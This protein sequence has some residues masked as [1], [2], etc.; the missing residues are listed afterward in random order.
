MAINYSD[1]WYDEESG[2]LFRSETSKHRNAGKSA[3]NTINGN[4]YRHTRVGNSMVPSHRIIWEMF[5][6]VLPKGLVIDH[7]NRNKLDN[8]LC[9][10]RAVTQAEN[11]R[12]RSG[13][14]GFT[15][16]KQ[17]NKFRAYFTRNSSPVELGDYDTALDARAAYLRALRKYEDSLEDC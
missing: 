2:R 7:I 4:G 12:N 14:K 17:R 5:N 9:N 8:R 11:T 10:L 16:S 1:Y 13:V 3:D 6:G 15:W